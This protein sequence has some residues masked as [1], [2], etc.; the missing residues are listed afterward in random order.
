MINSANV[1]AALPPAL[2]N[3]PIVSLA[4]T[5]STNLEAKRRLEGDTRV[6]F[7]VL[8]D[9]QT[10]GVGQRGHSFTS[11]DSS[12]LYM[13]LVI[14]QPRALHLL[15]PA[16]GVATVQAAA[17]LDAAP[18]QLK[19]VN[20]L[21]RGQTKIGGILCWLEQTPTPAAIIGIGLNIFP[22][23]DKI[24]LAS[25]Q[26][27]GTLYPSAPQSDLRGRLAGL[28]SAK[29]IEL[30]QAPEQIMPA[31]RKAA[32]YVGQAVR[33]ANGEQHVNGVLQGFADDGSVIIQTATGK[34]T[35]G[36]GSI[37]PQL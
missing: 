26:Q 21:T 18:L 33:L 30:M 6:P 34:V 15:M 28:I 9:T 22:N 35:A 25:D 13:S 19:W 17:V 3:M 8:A 4:S 11:P 31:Y 10:A 14:P 32:S 24:A 7:L 20:D 12:G 27:T 1:R 2:A 36:S 23:P 16:A 5:D 29:L 37:R